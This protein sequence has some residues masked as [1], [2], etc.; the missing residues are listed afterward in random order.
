[1]HFLLIPD[2]FKGSLTAKAVA[3][4]M[5]KTIR[6]KLPQSQCTVFP[7]SDGGEGA[8]DTLLD[9]VQGRWVTCKCVD[10]L[11][12][13]IQKPYFLFKNEATAWIELSQTAGLVLLKNEERNPLETSTLGVGMQIKHALDQG[14][15]TIILGIGGSATH[16]L[17]TGIFSA[18]GGVLLTKKGVPIFPCGK[19]LI[20][21]DHIDSS[22]L[23]PQIH[24]IKL[25]VA[26]DVSNP[27]LGPHG[28]AKI[29]APQK[30]ATP[31]MIK[32]L[33]EGGT[34][35]LSLL[36]NSISSQLETL[37]GGGAAGGVAAGLKGLFKAQLKSGFELL[38][39]KTALRQ[40]LKKTDVVLT[41]EGCFD[42]QSIHGKLPFRVAKMAAELNTPTLIFAGTT[43][44]Q[45]D[46]KILPKGTEVFNCTPSGQ[47]S[48]QAMV[49]AEENLTQQLFAVLDRF[50]TL[51]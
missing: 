38:A 13:P 34:H 27:L 18:L 31:K 4:I 17:G 15:Q 36:P 25:L 7:F 3:Q 33:E 26:C 39:K 45:I 43:S 46:T 28:A 6:S 21:I 29:Y 5:Q 24:K 32:R 35:F 44:A 47:R 40:V 1:M 16:D 22:Q 48:E 42:T 50:S 10:A 30:G 2:S 19:N 8:L 23:D 41:G 20:Q 49:N 12:R 14:C 9:K 37:S 51:S 11:N